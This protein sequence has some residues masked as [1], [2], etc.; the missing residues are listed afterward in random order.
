MAGQKG[1]KYDFLHFVPFNV[2]LKRK[3]VKIKERNVENLL[4]I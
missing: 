4:K 3:N 2:L 1:R